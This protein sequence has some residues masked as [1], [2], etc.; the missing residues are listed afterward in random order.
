VIGIVNSASGFT[1]P[2]R[3]VAVVLATAAIA[4]AWL[5]QTIRGQVWAIGVLGVASIALRALL[6]GPSSVI[7][8]VVAVA[9]SGIRLSTRAGAVTAGILG[10]AYLVVDVVATGGGLNL[11]TGFTALGLAFAFLL[12]LSV[13]RVREERERAEALLVELKGSRDAQVQ[14]AAL[15]ERTRIARDIHDVLA[16]TLSALAVQLESTRMLVEQRPG[17]PAAIAAIER[18]HR[19]AREGLDETRRAVG[20]LRGET[21]PGPQGLGRLAAEF[22]SASGVPCEVQVSGAPRALA[23][24]AQLAVYRTAQEALTNVRKHA[25]AT[26]VEVRL[27]YSESGTEL[28]IENDDGQHEPKFA[29]TGYGLVGMRERAELLG[30][31]FEAGP[32]AHGFRVRLWL[33][34]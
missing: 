28:V 30:G 5:A 10:I 3:L 26:Q 15:G 24:D 29:S 19:L 25:R 9:G 31:T 8:L 13:R 1:D 33:P 21:L 18:A 4:V 23:S 11:G 22:S 2:T 14:A 7:A 32:V 34:A 17:D 6:P 16:H 27:G 20:A 12:T